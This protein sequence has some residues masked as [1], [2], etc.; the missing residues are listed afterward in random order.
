MTGLVFALNVFFTVL[1]DTAYAV[2]AG[3]LFAAF[4]LNA[5]DAPAE[6]VAS[7]AKIVLRSLRRICIACL[8]GLILGQIVRPWFAAASMSGSGAFAANLAL[9][10]DILSSTH[11]GKVWY[12][13]S[14]ALVALVAATLFTGWQSGTPAGGPFAVS[15]ILVGCAKAASGHASGEGDFTLPELS[16]LLHVAGTAVWAGTVVASGFIVVPG[17]AKRRDPHSLWSYARLLSKIVTWALLAILLSGI[18]TSNREL[19]GSLSGLWSSGW[20][21]I[22]MAKIAFVTLALVLGA[23]T[24]FKCVRRPATSGR[25]ELMVRLLRA[26]AL[27]MIVI[28]CFSGLLANT[29]PAMTEG[30]NMRAPVLSN[31]PAFMTARNGPAAPAS[32][33]C[34]LPEPVCPAR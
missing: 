4:W 25:A 29:A 7:G 3:S 31:R 23:I 18:Y 27:V 12:V 15:L 22:L 9:V 34:Y 21:R 28:L 10:P 26:E 1:S 20:G 30:A 8:A 5:A 32:K 14:L 24:R 2:F 11:A 17:L 6:S 19:N 13:G 33:N 16:M